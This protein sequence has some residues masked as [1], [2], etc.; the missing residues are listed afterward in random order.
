MRKEIIILIILMITCI[1]VSGVHNLAFDKN[2]NFY[3][4]I[5]YS[6]VSKNLPVGSVKIYQGTIMRIKLHLFKQ[7]VW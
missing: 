1:I 2:G 7:Q 6:T 3:T 4:E 5:V